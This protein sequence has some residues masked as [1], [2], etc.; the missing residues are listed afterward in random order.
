MGS[1]SS[2]NTRATSLSASVLHPTTDAAIRV[3]FVTPTDTPLKQV[4]ACCQRRPAHVASRTSGTQPAVRTVRRV[5]RSPH[6]TL[7]ATPIH[8][9]VTQNKPR[10]DSLLLEVSSQGFRL[11]R[12]DTR[13]PL[14]AYPWSQVHSWKHAP[15]QFSFRFYDERH[16][17]P[18]SALTSAGNGAPF[19]QTEGRAVGW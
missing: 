18:V 5:T 12:L 10:D 19:T 2:R 11:L 7:N 6:S 1:G 17:P 13:D 8:F 3:F 15:S 16:V 4:R 14:A 9:H